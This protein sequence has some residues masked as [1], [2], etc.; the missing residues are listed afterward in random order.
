MQRN[1]REEATCII[2][3]LKPYSQNGQSLAAKQWSPIHNRQERPQEDELPLSCTLPDRPSEREQPSTNLALKTLK[4]ARIE[5]WNENKTWPTQK[6][7]STMDRFWQ[8]ADDDL[9][10]KRS[11]GRKRSNA[12]LSS[13]TTPT[14]ITCSMSREQK[15]APYKNVAFENQLRDHGSLLF[16]SELGIT[17]ESK[18]LCRQLLHKPRSVP[19]HTPFSD[20][21]SFEKTCRRITNENETKV[22][23]R[24]SEFIVPSAE[25][26]ADT[27]ADHLTH[28]RE[29]ANACWVN[30]KPFIYPPA[31]GSGSRSGPRPQPDFGFGFDRYA[32]SAEQLQK[33]QPFLGDPLTDF[34]LFAA[35]S[36]M[37]FPFLTCE[38]KCGDGGL[39]VADRQNAY[40]QSIIL[41]GLYRLFRLVA[42]EKELHR[43]I[44]GFSISH[45]AKD[46]RL[47]GHY[48]VI[49]GENVKFY[50]HPISEFIFKPT[51]EGDL[52]WKSYKFV[53]NI[54]DLWLPGHFKLICSVIDML[55][56]DLDTAISD[57]ARLHPSLRRDLDSSRSGLSQQVEN[58]NLA[59]DQAE[60]ATQPTA[61]LLTPETTTAETG[62]ANSRKKKTK[63]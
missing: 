10:S 25:T 49:K 17:A 3:P 28:I 14:Q 21:E 48:P 6:Q 4:E 19:Q 16:E 63:K 1:T 12:S 60:S 36:Q 57:Q 29:T 45:N 31:S 32:F 15:C 38:V 47:W 11:L 55:P 51:D 33:L 52:R 24:I 58:Y 46:V 13:E 30:Y 41:R 59:D 35:T 7:E 26:L 20:D 23:H 27:G 54:Y 53:R 42:R 8:L 50:R 34:S 62:P 43:T 22:I 39:T 44:I 40:A 18:E 5:F 37:Y 9:A 2:P 61:Q 56:A